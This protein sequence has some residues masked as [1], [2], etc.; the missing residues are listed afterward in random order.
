MPSLYPNSDYATLFTESDIVI[1]FQDL[2][3]KYYDS[4]TCITN[5]RQ[6]KQKMKIFD[7]NKYN[8]SRLH[9]HLQKTIIKIT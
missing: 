6:I 4:K 7:S 3:S 8:N 2:P 5:L 1:L 9:E